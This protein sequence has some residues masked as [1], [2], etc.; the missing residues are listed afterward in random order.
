MALTTEEAGGMCSTRSG[1]SSRGSWAL[2]WAAFL[3]LVGTILMM[4][5]PKPR[6]CLDE[7]KW[8]SVG[9]EINQQSSGLYGSKQLLV[10]V[11][12]HVPA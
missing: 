5:E 4:G 12:V 8:V 2:M 3:K 7:I 10:N 1:Q 11:L 6:K 9:Y